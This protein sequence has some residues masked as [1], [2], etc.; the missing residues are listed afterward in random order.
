MRIVVAIKQVGAL[1]DEFELLEDE[2]GVDPDFLDFSL[3]EWDRF[4]I[5]EALQL[6]DRANGEVI[7]V[8][9]GDDEVDQALRTALAMGADRAIHVVDD[10]SVEAG[11]PLAVARVLAEVA[12]RE[13]P[14]LVLFGAQASDMAYGATGIATAGY[15]EVPH[16]ALVKSIDADGRH[17]SLVVGRELEGG[18]LQ[19]LEVDL[20]ALLTVQSGL[21]EP[22]YV[23]MRAVMQAGTAS[24]DE[25]EL[26]DLGLEADQLCAGS[27]A[28]L[29]RMFLPTGTSSAEMLTG[30][31]SE[32]AEKIHS[33]VHKALNR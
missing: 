19:R 16:V 31:L 7:V 9:L 13:R 14:D 5:E 25:L 12:R 6:R 4:S 17:G 32:I 28:K 1:D 20:P 10:G 29:V 3:N 21:N 22:R 30:S 24:V 33:I 2:R 18:V 8:S 15:L 26:S 23:T 27:G 11:G